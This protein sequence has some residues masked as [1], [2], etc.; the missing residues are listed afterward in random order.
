MVE[1]HWKLERLTQE[2]ARKMVEEF[3]R[4]HAGPASDFN[5]P[6]E[7]EQQREFSQETIL[8]YELKR[9]LEEIRPGFENRVMIEYIKKKFINKI[10]NRK[11]FSP[12]IRP[13]AYYYILL[14]LSGLWSLLKKEDQRLIE[15]S[16]KYS[17][18]SISKSLE[19][20]KFNIKTGPKSIAAAKDAVEYYTIFK[21]S[22]LWLL[23][24]KE[25]QQWIEDNIRNPQLIESLIKELKLH[26][27][28]GKKL[29][30]SQEALFAINVYT[31]L[32]LSG[33]W[34]LLK[35]EDQQWI[36]ENIKDSQL[37]ENVIKE[38]SQNYIDLS[39][40]SS[41]GTPSWIDTWIYIG[42]YTFF[43]QFQ[44]ILEEEG[45]RKDALM[46]SQRAMKPEEEKEELPPIPQQRGF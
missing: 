31:Q 36:E 22:D 26:I 10:R 14:K 20:L 45:R 46:E 30:G 25:D 7:K 4:K 15:E 18:S 28:K 21:L 8:A 19:K 37:I 44:Q 16:V 23:I 42:R 9:F 40:K 39:K 3:K 35:E 34:S 38:L 6:E 43:S 29:G 11:S 13:D 1:K 27:D 17:S 12:E 41:R 2:E 5:L 33:L 24:V 32:K